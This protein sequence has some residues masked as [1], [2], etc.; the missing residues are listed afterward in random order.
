MRIRS[1]RVLNYK[2]FRDSGDVSLSPHMNVVVGANN[3]GK[4]AFLEAFLINSKPPKPYRSENQAA[5]DAGEQTSLGQFEIVFSGAYIRLFLRNT[6][7]RLTYQTNARDYDVATQKA[8]DLLDQD[9]KIGRIETGTGRS[10]SKNSTQLYLKN[11]PTPNANFYSVRIS[12]NKSNETNYENAGNGSGDDVVE[13]IA[14]SFWSSIYMFSAERMNIGEY[15]A[16]GEKILQPGALNLPACLNDLQANP[17]RLRE[18]AAHV[19][20][21]FP[22][23]KHVSVVTVGQFFH[24]RIWMADTKSQREDLAFP[25]KDCGTGVSQVLAIL[26]VVMTAP[27]GVIII[28]EPGSFLHPGAARRLI[29]IIKSY[30]RHQYIISTHSADLISVSGVENIHHVS[31]ANGE[32]S[33]SVIPAN[34]LDRMREVLSDLGVSFSDVFGHD[35]VVWVEGETEESCFPLLASVD[36]VGPKVAWR[37]VAATA[38]FEPSRKSKHRELVL[39]IYQRLTGLKTLMPVAVAFSFDR[40]TLTAKQMSDLINQSEGKISFI[41]RR[42]YENYLLHAAAIAAVASAEDGF[43]TITPQRVVDWVKKNGSTFAKSM[44]DNPLSDSNWMVAC[45]APKLLKSLFADLSEARVEYRKTRHSRL[46]TQWLIE[47][48]RPAIEELIKYVQILGESAANT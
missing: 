22:T 18:F 12:I 3:S 1:A 32:S 48:D 6:G 42:T 20:S 14:G 35:K 31:W 41:G 7:S 46:L 26:Y 38:D 8:I 28:D 43:G 4:S 25:L 15:A 24:I 9:D 19:N 45:D 17:D 40:E 11:Q 21:I 39:S 33:V 2:S 37:K 44:A 34:E 30:D 5:D 23:I 13:S 36:G 47:N 29:D 16:V 10:F 27:T